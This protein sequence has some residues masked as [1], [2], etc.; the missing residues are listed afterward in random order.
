MGMA[1]SQARLLAL[2]SRL[3][4][5]E[6][7]AQ[8]I[9]SQKLALT[10]Q[11]DGLYQKYCDALD[12]TKITVS[13]MGPDGT[14]RPVDA[15]YSTLCTYNSER[16]KQYALQDNLTGLLYTSKDVKDTY[17]MYDDDKYTFAYA[18]LGFGSQFGW[19]ANT[20]LGEQVGINTYQGTPGQFNIGD[21]LYMTECEVNVYNTYV[22]S[23]NV[24]AEKCEA[25]YQETDDEKKKVLLAEF[26]DYL[27]AEYGEEIFKEMNK[28][29]A[30]AVPPYPDFIDTTWPEIKSEFNYYVHLWEA[31]T[32]AG[33]CKVIDGEFESGEAGNEWLNNMVGAAMV[34]ILVWDDSGHNNEWSE[35]SVATSTNNNYLQ[36]VQDDKDLKRAEA[37]YEHE[38]S[39]INAKDTKFDNE[40]NKL[41]TERSAITTQME[42]IKK[43]KSENIE[44]TFGVFG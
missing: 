5:V 37:E 2:T 26:R 44:R 22:G 43:V 40:L 33:G 28:D 39:K 7:K 29:K 17:E 15:T 13:Y 23:D 36:E 34:T 27:Y 6:L 25:I 24:L 42:S 38:L 41:E 8:N 31:I 32:E 20:N 30:A 9:M 18:M 4:D 11:K 35:T 21:D 3:H 14:T 1:A 16:I 12:K 19:G 10:T